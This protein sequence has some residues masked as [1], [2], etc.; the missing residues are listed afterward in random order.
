MSIIRAL[1]GTEKRTAALFGD[2]AAYTIPTNGQTSS[3]VSY[4]TNSDGAMRHA[5]VYACVRIIAD[6]IGTFPV[7][8]YVG[9]PQM[10]LGVAERIEPKPPILTKPSDYL[11]G[12]QWVHQVMM[13]LLLQGNAY[14]MISAVDRL[15]YPTQ[16]DLLDPQKVT[17]DKARGGE[18][19]T[20]TGRPI[21]GGTKIFKIRSATLTSEQVWHCPGPMMPGDLA[22]L[23]PVKYAARAIGMGVEAEQFGLDFFQNG[24]HP[25]AVATTEQEVDEPTAQAV[26]ARLKAATQNRDIPVLGAGL[27][28]K[29]WMTTPEDSMLLEVLRV[30]QVMICQIFGVPP[31]MVG[32]ASRGSTITY[33][34]REQR[35]QDFLV[36]TINPWLVRLEDSF[37]LLFPRTTFV[38]FDTK[39]LLKSDLLARYQAWQIGLGNQPFLDVE[40]VRNFE[41]LPEMPE[42]EDPSADSPADDI[43]PVP[44]GSMPEQGPST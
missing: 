32:A 41:G 23:S 29:P 36:N 30:N 42:S 1:R 6:Q 19:N 34:N 27:T 10:N 4:S 31:E 7:D 39:N 12:V 25:T 11:S 24:I 22:G 37:S 35:A 44:A 40:E 28:L 33:A 15:G 21:P 26:K 43:P 38:K 16:I 9:D 13:S 5:A 17:V 20:A 2:P 8:A 14:G 3:V 18:L